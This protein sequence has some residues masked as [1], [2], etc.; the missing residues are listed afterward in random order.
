MIDLEAQPEAVSGEV[1]ALVVKAIDVA[2]ISQRSVADASSVATTSFHR[3]LGGD[4]RYEITL[5]QLRRIAWAL[6]I[7]PSSLLPES[8]RTCPCQASSSEVGLALASLGSDS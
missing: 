8:F 1:A 5:T 7:H 4:E 2:G 3:K 6:G